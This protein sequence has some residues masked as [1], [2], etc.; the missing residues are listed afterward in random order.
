MITSIRVNV[1]KPVLRRRPFPCEESRALCMPLPALHTPGS[2]FG[3]CDPI[4]RRVNPACLTMMENRS[5]VPC[6]P[7][8]AATL[9][10]SGGLYKGSDPG[11]L[12]GRTRPLSGF[13][14]GFPGVRKAPKATV[15]YRSC[16]YMEALR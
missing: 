14:P 3:V 4:F 7:G 16:E 6:D 2:W 10:P 9:I 8:Y 11:P 15:I 13:S 5:Q 1:P 12:P